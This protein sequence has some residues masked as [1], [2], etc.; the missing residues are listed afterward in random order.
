MYLNI[1]S[2]ERRD[3]AGRLIFTCLVT[4]FITLVVSIMDGREQHSLSQIVYSYAIAL[5]SWFFIDVGDLLVFKTAGKRFPLTRNRYLFVFVCNIAAHLLGTL[6]GDGYS[7]WQMLEAQPLRVLLW[8][9]ILQVSTFSIIWFFTL[10]HRHNEDRQSSNDMRLRLLESQLEPHMLFN[11]L[12]NMRALISTDPVLA[13]QMLDRIVDYMRANLDGS[14]TQMHPLSAEFDRIDDYLDIMKMRMGKRLSY[15]L[16]LAPELQHHP[17]PP[18]ILQPLVENA[19]KHGLEP[20]IDGGRI[21]IK[22]E[23][24]NNT[25]VLEVND[26]GTGVNK[27][28]LLQS[29]GFGWTQVSERLLTMYGHKSTIN[30]IATE[31]YKTSAV[32]TFPYQK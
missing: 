21:F 26:T 23:I 6:I 20:Q 14:R 12:A 16:Y 18:F 3:M 24:V 25:V 29:K 15:S 11:T 31:A 17:V 5:L 1:P 10:R 22:A 9:I 19:I 28:D 2:Q 13:T 27:D 8:H 30:L 32:I 4:A 7:G